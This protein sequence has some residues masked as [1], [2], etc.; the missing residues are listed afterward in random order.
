MK[1]YI[2]KSL[3]KN[4]T[5]I[6][7]KISDLDKEKLERPS[8]KKE[9]DKTLGNSKNNK[10]PGLDGYSPEFYKYFWPN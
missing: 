5:C 6:P 7:Q 2:R 1:N 8:T 4:P 9:L 3:L 10:S